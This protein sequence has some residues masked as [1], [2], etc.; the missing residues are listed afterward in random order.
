MHSH[1]NRPE[2][3]QS[4]AHTLAHAHQCA[5]LACCYIRTL[6][7]GTGWLTQVPPISVR[8]LRG[9]G[10]LRSDALRCQGVLV[11]ME[12]KLNG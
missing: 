11:C 12:M 5:A 4:T 8:I 9:F 6:G 2:L 3:D 1:Y 7:P 10:R